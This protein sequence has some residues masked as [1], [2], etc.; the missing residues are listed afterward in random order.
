MRIP[1]TRGLAALTIT[2]VAVFGLTACIGSPTGSS[3]AGI[4]LSSD[5]PG[6]EGQSK[7]DACALIQQSIEDATQEFES[8]PSD[9]PAAV[10]DSMKEAAVRIADT[11]GK[12]T[13]DE[14]A[15]IVPS[16]QAM[17]AEAGEVMEAVASGDVSKVEDLSQLGTRFQ[18]TSDAFQEIC[19]P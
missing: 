7:E 2:V 1:T 13:N 6:D 10:V 5:E 15:A 17:F 16:L 19:A 3:S 11:A 4:P 9:D 14:V 18:E 12:I 8:A